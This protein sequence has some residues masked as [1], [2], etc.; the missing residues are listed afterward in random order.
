[1]QGIPSIPHRNAATPASSAPHATCGPSAPTSRAATLA[2][3]HMLQRELLLVDCP[4][5][6]NAD[7]AHAP[8]VQGCLML[9]TSAD[10]AYACCNSWKHPLAS[11]HGADSC[12]GGAGQRQ[13]PLTLP[14]VLPG[15]AHLHAICPDL[16]LSSL[17]C[18]ACST[19]GTHA[20]SHR[21][22]LVHNSWQQATACL[23]Y[24]RIL[25]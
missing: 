6:R 18:N 3:R 24:G 25:S 20:T 21:P 14:L 19:K 5:S 7:N 23:H 22:A 2:A 8:A 9:G 16:E 10:Q 1:M 11:V 17:A 15:Q 13:A 12:C 4:A